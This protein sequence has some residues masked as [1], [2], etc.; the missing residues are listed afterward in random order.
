MPEVGHSGHL[1]STWN[2]LTERYCR[3]LPRGTKSYIFNQL[4]HILEHCGGCNMVI[5]LADERTMPICARASAH[6]SSCLRIAVAQYQPDLGP[7]W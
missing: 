4:A 3:R 7:P 2:D 5:E 1:L 6:G